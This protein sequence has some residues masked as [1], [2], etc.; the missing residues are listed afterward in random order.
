MDITL[1]RGR[2]ETILSGITAT[3]TTKPLDCHNA[4]AIILYFNLTAG[5][6]TWTV[7]IQGKASDGTYIDMY[8]VNGNAMELTGVT[9]DKAQIFVGIP[10]EFK[11]VAT[12]DVDGA[13]VS[14]GYELLSV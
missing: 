1:Q 9:A 12:E 14:I 7:K 5:S 8:D 13:T 10:N 6:G 2:A 11:I 4:N 3:T